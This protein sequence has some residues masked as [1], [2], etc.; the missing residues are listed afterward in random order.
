MAGPARDW[1]TAIL[2]K[3]NEIIDKVKGNL[4]VSG[5]LD[6]EAT[7]CY[8]S[9]LLSDV[10]ANSK[11]GELWITHHTH[12][13]VVAVAAVKELSAVI[14]V[15]G[16]NI[17]PETM[18]RAEAERV[19]LLTSPLSAFEAAGSVFNLLKAGKPA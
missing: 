4:L 18:K 8:V 9:D 6:I 3:V 16:K 10:L 2:A 1:R 13:N 5:N 19:T 12:P 11:T 15:G 14:I 7:G 17:E